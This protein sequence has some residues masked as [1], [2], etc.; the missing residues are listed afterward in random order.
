MFCKDKMILPVFHK[1]HA[2]NV[3][4]YIIQLELGTSL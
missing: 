1:L 3:S 2:F 4:I